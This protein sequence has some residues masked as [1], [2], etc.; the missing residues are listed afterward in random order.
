MNGLVGSAICTFSLSS[1]D[2]ALNGKF[3]EQTSSLSAWLPVL[4]SKVPEPRPGSCVNDTQTLPDAV[5]NFIRSHPLADSAVTHDNR[6][7][8]FYTKDVIFRRIVVQK[9]EVDGVQY[10][11]F[12]AGTK[13]G[14]VY[15]LVEWY[16]GTGQAYSNL[17]DVYDVTAPE[18]IQAMEISSKVKMR[19]LSND[20]VF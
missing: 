15:K 10:T 14:F 4:T 19:L 11:I 20:A 3:K 5:L 8:L 17:V 2:E 16:D 1:I 9:L 7:P 12:Y 6:K 13:T 18:P